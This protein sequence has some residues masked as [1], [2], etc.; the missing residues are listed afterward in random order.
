MQIWT[1]TLIFKVS[2]FNCSFKFLIQKQLRKVSFFFITCRQVESVIYHSFEFKHTHTY[3]IEC[4]K[5]MLIYRSFEFKHNHT[6]HIECIKQ[7]LIYHSFE[8]IQNNI[9]HEY[10]IV[11]ESFYQSKDYLQDFL[12]WWTLLL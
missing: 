11:I 6:H 3:Y 7:M 9:Q 5:Q 10:T 8:F 1:N 2:C 4:I 12:I